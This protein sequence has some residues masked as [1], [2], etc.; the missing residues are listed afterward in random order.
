MSRRDVRLMSSRICAVR[1]RTSG[2]FSTLFQNA[3]LCPVAHSTAQRRFSHT[4]MLANTL[5][6]WK[7]RD[8]PRRLIL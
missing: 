4:V 5:V 8:R 6:T 2:R 7:L 1:S 3:Y